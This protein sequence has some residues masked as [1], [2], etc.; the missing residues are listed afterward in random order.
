MLDDKPR[1]P[2]YVRS[3]EL[4]DLAP[5]RVAVDDRE[6]RVEKLC[7]Q[8]VHPH[9]ARAM[10]AKDMAAEP[11]IDN[12]PEIEARAKELVAQKGVSIV[13]GRCM[14]RREGLA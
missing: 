8:D 9:S 6:A 3:D 14:A 11:R 10:V 13:V 2:P 4:S 1:R 12:P 5:T 7:R